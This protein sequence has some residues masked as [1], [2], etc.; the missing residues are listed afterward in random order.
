MKR[1]PDRLEQGLFMLEFIG[2][3]LASHKAFAKM[4]DAGIAVLAKT[5]LQETVE[6]YKEV[7]E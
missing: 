1:M 6:D 4:T 5:K 7:E 2:F 3:Y